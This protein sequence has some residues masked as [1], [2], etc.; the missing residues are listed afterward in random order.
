MNVSELRLKRGQL[1]N[2]M[3]AMIDQYP[4]E[5][6]TADIERKYLSLD[7]EQMQIK[8]QIGQDSLDKEM[9]TVI[10][11]RVITGLG[12]GSQT[13]AASPEYKKAF[14]N[15]CRVGQNNIGPDDMK[16]LNAL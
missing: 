13:G 6:W 15:L 8:S 1:V 12:G 10:G 5:K 16:R 14:L 11:K 9:D 3:R 4:G 2:Q 7:G